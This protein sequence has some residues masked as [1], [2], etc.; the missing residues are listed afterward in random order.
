M[1]R[2][3]LI[4]DKVNTERV[5]NYDNDSFRTL[6]SRGFCNVGPKA[7]NGIPTTSWSAWVDMTRKALRA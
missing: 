1:I 5:R 2:E 7:M 3:N 6:A 4:I